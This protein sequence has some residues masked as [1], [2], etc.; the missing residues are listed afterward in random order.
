M[1]L[2]DQRLFAGDLGNAHTDID[3][4]VVDRAAGLVDL[5]AFS[6][7]VEANH[8]LDLGEEGAL[9]A[10]DGLEDVKAKDLGLAPNAEIH[11]T[12]LLDGGDQG[13]GVGNVLEEGTSP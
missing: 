3:H 5:N 12:R 8:V 7:H 10:L 4:F 2:T 11:L 6:L 1:G 13:L 9:R